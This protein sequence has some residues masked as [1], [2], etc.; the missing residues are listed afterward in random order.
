MKL[1]LKIILV[2]CALQLP[3]AQNERLRKRASTTYRRVRKTIGF[4]L[5]SFFL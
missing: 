4:T 5:I 1:F 2:A 3:M